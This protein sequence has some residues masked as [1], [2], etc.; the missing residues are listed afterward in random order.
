MLEKKMV[1]ER[2]VFILFYFK[3]LRKYV[4]FDEPSTLKA[5]VFFSI[6]LFETFVKNLVQPPHPQM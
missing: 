5:Q 1:F 2:Y 6:I 3:R 4:N